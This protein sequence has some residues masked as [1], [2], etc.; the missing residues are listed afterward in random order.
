MIIKPDRNATSR[1]CLDRRPVRKEKWGNDLHTWMRNRGRLDLQID[2][3]DDLVAR[4]SQW[5]WKHTIQ[6]ELIRSF[7]WPTQGILLSTFS[8]ALRFACA[9]VYECVRAY[10]YSR[11]IMH[12]RKPVRTSISRYVCSVYVSVHAC[13][14]ACLSVCIYLLCVVCVYTVHVLVTE[15][16]N[17]YCT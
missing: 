17:Q 5:I 11:I 4:R 6:L 10:M 16:I 13:M 12:A 14:C 1:N 15:H 9:C 7:E 2:V 3:R 8:F